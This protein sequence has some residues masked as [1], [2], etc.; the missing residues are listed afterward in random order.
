MEELELISQLFSQFFG[1]YWGV[2]AFTLLCTIC[3][4][5]AAFM[6][7]PAES[8]GA[9]YRA[10]YKVVNTLAVNVLKAKN[11]DEVVSGEKK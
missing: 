9:F 4:I 11:A 2:T 3:A 10:V 8:S 5:A 6:K 1:E 7:A